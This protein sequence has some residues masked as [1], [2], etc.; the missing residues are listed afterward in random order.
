[1]LNPYSFA[2]NSQRNSSIISNGS[3]GAKPPSSFADYLKRL[4]QKFFSLFRNG[5]S[6]GKNILWGASI[7]RTF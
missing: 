4:L 7:G 2:G 3:F 5:Y 1:M 6:I